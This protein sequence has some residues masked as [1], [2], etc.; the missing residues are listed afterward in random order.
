VEIEEIA[1]RENK[2][3]SR[4]EIDYRVSHVG[5]PSPRRNELIDAVMNRENTVR[6]TI[7]VY[8]IDTRFGTGISKAQIRVY[9]DAD[10]MRSIERDFMLKRNKLFI[11]KKTEVKE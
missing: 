10:S 2:L 4:T 6:D 8:A 7:I 11:E 9:T 3:L 1:R 5:G